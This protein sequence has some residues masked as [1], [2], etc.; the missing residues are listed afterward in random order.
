MGEVPMYIPPL[1]PP[2]V[3]PPL[4]RNALPLTFPPPVGPE[5]DWPDDFGRSPEVVEEGPGFFD[6]LEF[7][8]IG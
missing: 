6:D 2:P 4:R 5:E 7:F 8:G 1:F 3:P